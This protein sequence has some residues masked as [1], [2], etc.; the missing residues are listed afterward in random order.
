ME[1]T[2]SETTVIFLRYPHV[3]LHWRH[4]WFAMCLAV[5]G[6]HVGIVQVGTYIKC[7]FNR[8]CTI[9]SVGGFYVQHLLHTIYLLFN[10]RCYG[11]LH[12]YRIGTGIRPV[13]FIMGGLISGYCEMGTP[14]SV[15]NP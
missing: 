6:K 4:K 8:T 12:I 11:L 2:S 1:T 10:R 14:F 7:Y 13:I 3:V 15:S 9:R 5:L